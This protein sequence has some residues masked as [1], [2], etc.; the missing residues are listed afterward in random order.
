MLCSPDGNKIKK[1]LKK[2]KNIYIF[3]STIIFAI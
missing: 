3:H 2:S 1:E